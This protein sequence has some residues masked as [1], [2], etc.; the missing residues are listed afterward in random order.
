MSQLLKAIDSVLESTEI[1]KDVK[2]G[3]WGLSTGFPSIDKLLGGVHNGEYTIL[4]ARTSQGKSALAVQIAREISINLLVKTR[5]TGEDAG[6]VL[7]FSPEMTSDQLV[8]RIASNISEVSSTTVKAG[9]ASEDELD[10]W[11]RALNSIRKIDPH[12]VLHSGESMDVMDIKHSVEVAS[13]IGSPIKLVVIDYLQR[14]AA[15]QVRDAYERA[16]IISATLKDITNK[17]NIPLI[18]LSQLNRGADRTGKGKDGEEEDRPPKLSDLRDSGRIEEDA[19]AVWLLHR[20]NAVQKYSGTGEE[21]PQ[22]ATLQVAKNRNGRI[23]T[24]GLYF[25]PDIATFEDFG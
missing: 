21:Q 15:G 13:N 16:N 19:D 6:R 12:F 18:V 9:K 5:E 8:Q 1:W 7:Y 23:G 22:A 24:L 14:L 2:D 20:P 10:R 3:I 25:N 17:H 4:A 11:R